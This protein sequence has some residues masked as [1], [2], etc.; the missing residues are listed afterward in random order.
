MRAIQGPLTL[1]EFD[2]Q[3]YL[4][5]GGFDG[6]RISAVDQLQ[7]ILLHD[8]AHLSADVII[9]TRQQAIAPLND[10]DAAPKSPVQL[11]EFETNVATAKDQQ[12]LGHRL[13]L[14]DGGGIERLHSIQ[15][16]QWRTRRATSS[17]DED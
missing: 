1:G 16:G 8:A 12:V 3:A 14:H 4:P 17:V 5:V 11:P 6:L 15:T 9:L 2:P 10:G 13:E 7:A